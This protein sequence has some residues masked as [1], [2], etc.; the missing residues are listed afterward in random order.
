MSE[1]KFTPYEK[2]LISEIEGLEKKLEQAEARVAMQADCLNKIK[3]TAINAPYSHKMKWIAEHF[4]EA[5]KGGRR[6][7][8]MHDRIMDLKS[9]GKTSQVSQIHFNNA[10][11]RAA[12]IAKDG[13]AR[14]S[15]LQELC[16]NIHRDLLLRSEPERDDSE[17]KVV[18]LSAGYWE[19]LCSAVKQAADEAE[20]SGKAVGDL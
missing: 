13:D 5:E 1:V 16:I 15:D 14:I 19:S 18:N 6:V 2:K 10:K 7:V 12:E 3:N 20:K 17:V 11:M 4:D 8:N 9:I